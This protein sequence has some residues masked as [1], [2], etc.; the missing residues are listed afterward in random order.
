MGLKPR[1]CFLLFLL[2]IIAS[3]HDITLIFA[4]VSACVLKVAVASISI[5]FVQCFRQFVS[6]D[7]TAFGPE[8]YGPA[9]RK[10]LH[11][12]TPRKQMDTR[13]R[14]RSRSTVR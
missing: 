9:I 2:P 10:D 7:Y 4:G 8:S 1:D 11:S 14:S 5:V 3:D 12:Q 6:T 13:S